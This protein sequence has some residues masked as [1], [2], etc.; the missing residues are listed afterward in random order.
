M[1]EN[2]ILNAQIE[3]SVIEN[4]YFK[5]YKHSFRAW[6]VRYAH[7][8]SETPKYFNKINSPPFRQ[9]S[10]FSSFGH[11]ASQVNIIKR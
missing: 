11:A 7:T 3:S 4:F 2:T 1:R 6:K 9:F 5:H 10:S 8:P